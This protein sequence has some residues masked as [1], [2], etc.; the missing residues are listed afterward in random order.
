MKRM[1][2]IL[3]MV[4]AAAV[5][6]RAEDGG[7]MSGVLGGVGDPP[8][9]DDKVSTPGAG[10][11]GRAA[12]DKPGPAST[13]VRPDKKLRDDIRR[14]EQRIADMEKA[15]PASLKPVE[16]VAEAEKRVDL[17]ETRSAFPI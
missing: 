7:G 5:A 16:S 9:H 11:P 8:S 10:K 1:A 15:T 12:Q 2:P 6:A 4:F 13:G 3:L 17:R 14:L